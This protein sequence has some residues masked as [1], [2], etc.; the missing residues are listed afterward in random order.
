MTQKETNWE[1]RFE[2]QFPADPYGD[3]EGGEVLAYSVDAREVKQFIREA[4]ATQKEEILGEVLETDI[5]TEAHD[6]DG[7]RYQIPNSKTEEWKE[8]CEIPE[9][10]ERSWEVPE[11]AERIDGKEIKQHGMNKLI[12]SIRNSDSAKGEEK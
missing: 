2:E 7:H 3:F 12:N 6:N 4:L 1:K 11:W 10:D 5:Y 8:F 9:E